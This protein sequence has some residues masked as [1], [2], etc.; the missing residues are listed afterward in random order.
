MFVQIF[1]AFIELWQDRQKPFIVDA[2]GWQVEFLQ[3]Q[4]IND[5]LNEYILY[6]QAAM[7]FKVQSSQTLYSSLQLHL[8]I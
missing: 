8:K 2:A 4:R 1:N 7:H 3:Q 5:N 6:S